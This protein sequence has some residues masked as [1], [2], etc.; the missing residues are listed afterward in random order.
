M[1]NTVYNPMD[2]GFKD[3]A[4]SDPRAMMHLTGRLPITAEATVTKVGPEVRAPAKLADHLSIVETPEET[5]LDQT[6]AVG[7]WTT[8]QRDAV[9]E[10]ITAATLVPGFKGLKIKLTTTASRTWPSS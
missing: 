1:V 8:E 7:W 2:H 4:E 3:L 10:R 9:R 6:E 5:W